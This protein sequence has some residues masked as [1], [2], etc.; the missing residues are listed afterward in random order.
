MTSSRPD[1]FRYCSNLH[2]YHSTW[3]MLSVF[4]I[5]TSSFTPQFPLSLDLSRPPTTPH[6]SHSL[7]FHLWLSLIPRLVLEDINTILLYVTLFWRVYLSYWQMPTTREPQE[8]PQSSLQF[9][10]IHQLHRRSIRKFDANGMRQNEGWLPDYKG[11]SL[12]RIKREILG[13]G[14]QLTKVI[15]SLSTNPLFSREILC[16]YVCYKRTVSHTG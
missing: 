8:Q 7:S 3:G 1:G 16:V 6:V 14:G 13:S 9:A 2:H 11:L 5:S 4:I 15:C 10:S 12:L